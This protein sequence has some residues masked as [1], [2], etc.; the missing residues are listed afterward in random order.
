[1]VSLGDAAKAEAFKL[2]QKLRS[3]NVPVEMD[4]QGKSMKAQ[5]KYAN[6]IKAKY[7]I[8]IG[9][10]ELSNNSQI[11]RYMSASKQ[12]LVKVEGILEHINEIYTV[13]K[14]SNLYTS[15][16]YNLDEVLYGYYSNPDSSELS[17]NSNVLKL[18]HRLFE[19]LY[20]KHVE[21]NNLTDNVSIHKSSEFENYKEFVAD[22]ISY[23]AGYKIKNRKG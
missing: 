6:K 9:D 1:V 4:G 22:L 12:E 13:L 18:I 3:L 11:I 20:S 23:I 19:K 7:V 8:I 5:L 21:L 10:D 14:H 16:E 15:K 2:C 17:S